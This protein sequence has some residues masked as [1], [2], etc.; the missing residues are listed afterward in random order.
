MELKDWGMNFHDSGGEH[1][2]FKASDR[3]EPDAGPSYY[4][5]VSLP[6]REGNVRWIIMRETTTANTTETRYTKVGS[7]LYSDNWTLRVSLDYH[8]YYEIL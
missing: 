6:D 1:A 3:D 2:D 8:Y 4:G 7:G 5:F